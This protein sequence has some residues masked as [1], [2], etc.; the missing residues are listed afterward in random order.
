LLDAAIDEGNR[1]KDLIRNLPEFNWPFSGKKTAMNLH[2]TF[3]A[4][5]VLQ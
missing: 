2:Q 1:I 5:L 3:D 4:L